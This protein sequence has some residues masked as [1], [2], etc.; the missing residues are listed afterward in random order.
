ME[1]GGG[2]RNERHSVDQRLHT[3]ALSTEI[4]ELRVTA[5]HSS[6]TGHIVTVLQFRNTKKLGRANCYSFSLRT[7]SMKPKAFRAFLK[8]FDFLFK[9]FA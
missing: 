9:K 6:V 3:E 1:D 7:E 5:T 8:F 4:P 2:G